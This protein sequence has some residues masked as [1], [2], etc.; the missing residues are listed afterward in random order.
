M[1]DDLYHFK[2]H[3]VVVNTCFYK[4]SYLFLIGFFF[5]LLFCKGFITAGLLDFQSA[6]HAW[7]F[8]IGH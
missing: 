6:L 8:S 7:T 1:S 3:V 4:F 5:Y 2:G